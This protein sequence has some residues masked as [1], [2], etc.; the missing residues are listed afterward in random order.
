LSTT[1]NAGF[2]TSVLASPTNVYMGAY[3]L[4]LEVRNFAQKYLGKWVGR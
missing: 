1:L 3:Y 2:M 4:G